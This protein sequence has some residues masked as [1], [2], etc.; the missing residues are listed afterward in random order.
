MTSADAGSPEIAIQN[1][2]RYV[3]ARELATWAARVV[4]Q[5]AP[6]ASG[7]GL[8]LTDDEEMCEL[9]GRFRNKPVTTDV[10]SFPGELEGADRTESGYMGDIA[11]SVPT[12]TA[13]ATEHGH[14]VLR[15]LKILFLHGALHCLGYD[16]E[17]DDGEMLSLETE[18]VERWI[19]ND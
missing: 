11:I 18:L 7:V 10:L 13:Q 3:G 8:L 19:Q 17:T 2:S 16:H 4:P 5:V 14:S 15:E 9:N 1:P 6:A 12:A